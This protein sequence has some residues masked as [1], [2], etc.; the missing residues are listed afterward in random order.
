MLKNKATFNEENEA[1]LVQEDDATLNEDQ[2]EVV[3]CRDKSTI[4]SAS[5]GTGKTTTMIKRLL[6]MVV[7]DKVDLSKV[8]VVTFTKLAA[9]NMREKLAEKFMELSKKFA[10][11]NQMEMLQRVVEQTE[12]LDNCAISTLHSFCATLLRNYFHVVDIDPSFTMLDDYALSNLKN[13]CIKKV[14]E[15]YYNADDE[16]FDKLFKIYATKRNDTNFVKEVLRLYEKSRTHVD[17]YQWYQDVRNSSLNFKGSK[18]ETEFNKMLSNILQDLHKQWLH[19]ADIGKQYGVNFY[20]EACQDWANLFSASPDN[21]F[22]QN[23]TIARKYVE[24]CKKI[25]IPRSNENKWRKLVSD[26]VIAM[27]VGRYQDLK[28]ESAS[29]LNPYV[30]FEEGITYDQLLEQ[31]AQM[32]VYIDKFMEVLQRFDDLFADEKRKMG[33][34]D[35]NDLEHFALAILKNQECNEEIRT[36]YPYIFVDEHQDTNP[37]QAEIIKQ[38]AGDNVLFLVGDVK[39]SIYGFRG[40][41]PQNFVDSIKEFQ[42]D[43][44]RKYVELNQNYRS[45]KGILNFVNVLMDGVMTEDFGGLDYNNTSM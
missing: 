33:V 6:K 13:K 4:V 22:E 16:V 44:N 38:L 24:G 17:F 28:K 29:K 2:K 21:T 34:V 40:C 43:P 15:D 42:Q 8:V 19:C 20:V 10:N 35:F 26:D 7:Y 25:S 36:Q 23:F 11:T 27:L 9:N 1:T 3:A 5:A 12:K 37:V 45:H 30:D 39:Q 14:L 41:T 18:L 32:V 31:S